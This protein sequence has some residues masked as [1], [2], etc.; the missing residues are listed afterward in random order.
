MLLSL[1]LS[2]I[3]YVVLPLVPLRR[4]E[5][6]LLVTPKYGYFRDLLPLVSVVGLFYPLFF[7]LCLSQISLHAV[8]PSELW[9]SSFSETLILA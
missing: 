9:S 3:S 6:G 4:G 8:L 5:A 2:V 1:L 7:L